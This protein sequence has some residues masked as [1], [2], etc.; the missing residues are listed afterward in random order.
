MKRVV[1]QALVFFWF[2]ATL[3]SCKHE[4]PKEARYIPKEANF[5]LALDPG[6]MKD[7]LQKGGI[8]VDTLLSKVF[9]RDS[10]DMRDKAKLEEL[11]NNAGIDWSSKI[12]VFGSQKTHA[13]NSLSNSFSLLGGL[14]DAAK[15]EAY[16][17]KQEETRGREIKKEKDYRYLINN[18][19]SMLAWN[20]QQVI[21]TI[22]TH[23]LKPVYDTNTMSFRKPP[24]LNTEEEMKREV[25]RYFTQKIK[26][27]MAG[28]SVFTDMFKEKA[29]G[30]AF[31]SANNSLAALSMMPF[32]LPKLEELVKDNYVTATLSF[33]DGKIL[34]KST[35]YTNQLLSSVLKQYA[36]PTVNLSMLDH[37][38]S[39]NINAIMLAAFNP[40]IFGG[41]LKQL[42]I[43]GL[44][45][46]FLEKSG[47]SSQD[48]YKSLKGDIAVIVSDFG[49][50][51]AEPEA[52][53]D[54]RSMMRKKPVGKMILTAPVGDKVSFAK[55]M[56]KA[57][58]QGFLV[59]QKNIY[60]AGNLLS[61]AG[62]YIMADDKN[63]V[64]ASDSV[65]YSEYMA[66]TSKV[67]INKEALDR[68]KGKST[69]FYIDVANTLNG[70]TKEANGTFRQ[71]L[72]TAK[73]TFR[74]V[75][76]TS[77]NFDGKSI[78]A[79]LEIRMQNEKQNSLVTLT[80]LIT[81]IA[82]DMRV[83]AK[84]ERETE[85]KMFLGGVPPIIR[86]N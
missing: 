74:D 9:K 47:I 76:A 80:S 25:D 12:F 33:E 63:L 40:E 5:V 18:E 66:Q 73:N 22:Y 16:L 68:F 55:L 3:A 30:Y 86:T 71:S 6:Q 41:L 20:D 61:I 36:G 53:H 46:N 42:E 2:A 32:Q 35:S 4:V 48:L 58:E 70:F 85:E 43:E 13:D 84:K 15:L 64:V 52:K 67:T 19:G 45:N 7:K 38:P 54:E 14:E 31:T 8:N 50:T 39:Q 77:D 82:V 34:A 57:V 49:M 44:A 28:L 78:Q 29:D 26:E 10:V 37:Y 24:H 72:N 59:K 17:Q 62:M 27:S 83:Q 23:N 56:D 11:K 79:Q 69:V 75:L 81:D 1:Y 60:K 65:T 51:A 21:V